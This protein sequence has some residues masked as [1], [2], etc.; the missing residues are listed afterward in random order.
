MCCARAVLN[1]FTMAKS[2]QKLT[3]HIANIKTYQFLVSPA[4][5]KAEELR[6]AF[7]SLLAGCQTLCSPPLSPPPLH[8][9]PFATASNKQHP[10]GRLTCQFIS[11]D[12]DE[13]S[14]ACPIMFLQDFIRLL[15]SDIQFHIF[16]VE[17]SH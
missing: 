7:Q 17:L 12:S 1:S 14:Q 8:E 4:L 11:L 13:L 16:T 6:N 10:A 3:V 2:I 5:L 15:L 9:Q